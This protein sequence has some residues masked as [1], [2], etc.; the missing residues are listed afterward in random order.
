M[1]T[2]KNKERFEQ[3]LECIDFSGVK[4]EEYYLTNWFR[5]LP[6]SMQ[7]GVYQ[8]YADSLDIE[9]LIVKSRA[10]SHYRASIIGTGKYTKWFKTRDE[11]RK[12]AIKAFDEIVN[13][14]LKQ[15]EVE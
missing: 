8:D 13:R 5:D 10:S 12:A 11:A 4:M 7:F 9:V 15:K 14:E 3:Y 1:L 2:G 6:L